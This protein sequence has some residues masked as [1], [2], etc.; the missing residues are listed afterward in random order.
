MRRSPE[1]LIVDAAKVFSERHGRPP[2]ACGVGPGRVEILGNHTDYNGGGVLAAALDRHVVAVGRPVA[3]PRV[4]VY[5]LNLDSSTEF[6]VDTLWP[7]GRPE[8]SSYVK[9]A[10]AVLRQAGV[11]VGGMEVVVTGDVPLGAGL[12][13]SAALETAVAMLILR[14]HP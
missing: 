3:G 6:R 14:F 7:E 12:G 1:H 8:W 9:S 13:S 4:E 10:F 5:A 2:T 11:A